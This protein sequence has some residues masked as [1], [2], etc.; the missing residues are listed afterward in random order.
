MSAGAW[1]AY[2]SRIAGRTSPTRSRKSPEIKPFC[3]HRSTY[4]S[5]AH[6][7]KDRVL[8]DSIVQPKFS[9]STLSVTDKLLARERWHQQALAGCYGPELVFM[10]P[11][12]GLRKGNPT[13]RKDAQKYVYA[14]E[15]YSYYNRGQD[16]VYYCHKGRRTET[17]WE[18]AKCIMQESCPDAVMLG[19][20][21]HRGT[22]RSYIFALHPEKEEFYRVLLKD[23][24]ETAWKD[25]FTSEPISQA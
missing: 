3:G 8:L 17:Q 6:C 25:C 22:Q 20:T 15:A 9:D 10:D 1:A 7:I 4:S 5:Q 21:Y 23:F 11:D 18:K 16:V 2:R 12:N 19:I 14:S 13:A 24:L